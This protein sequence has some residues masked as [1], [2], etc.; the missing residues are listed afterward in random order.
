MTK[1]SVSGNKLELFSSSRKNNKA[2]QTENIFI[3]DSILNVEPS[4]S[5]AII[6]ENHKTGE[7]EKNESIT[8]EYGGTMDCDENIK[9]DIPNALIESTKRDKT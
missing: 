2:E 6:S 4:F 8:Y 5:S 3:R 7:S 9:N 1:F